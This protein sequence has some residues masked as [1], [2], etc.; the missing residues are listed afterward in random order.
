MTTAAARSPAGAAAGQPPPIRVLLADDHAMLR[1]GIRLSLE[2]M[3]DMVVVAEAD[4]GASAVQQTAETQPDVVVLDVTMPRLN[5]LEAL[6]QIKRTPPR[7]A[8]G[9]RSFAGNETY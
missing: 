7:R 5:G 1:E 6:R 8:G 3:G 2:A 9:V 4:D